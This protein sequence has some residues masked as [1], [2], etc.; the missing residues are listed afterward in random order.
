MPAVTDIHAV[1]ADGARQTVI[2]ETSDAFSIGY[3]NMPVTSQ[4]IFDIVYKK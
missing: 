4:K 3:V 2:G 1:I